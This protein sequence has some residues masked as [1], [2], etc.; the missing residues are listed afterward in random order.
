MEDEHCNLA[1]VVFLELYE[2]STTTI[3]CYYTVNHFKKT[4]N[5]APEQF[6]SSTFLTF[7]FSFENVPSQVWWYRL[8]E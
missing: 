1:F 7:V 3:Y 4:N 8:L 5:V 2:G 6:M